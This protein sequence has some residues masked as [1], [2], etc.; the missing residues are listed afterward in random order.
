MKYKSV[1]K[2]SLFCKTL[3]PAF[4]NIYSH[5]CK[6][7]HENTLVSTLFFQIG[8]SNYHNLYITQHFLCILYYIGILFAH[9]FHYPHV[10]HGFIEYENMII[11]L[12]RV[13]YFSTQHCQCWISHHKI[14]WS[15]EA[16]RFGFRLLD[17]LRNLS[18]TSAAALPR[19]LSNLQAI[20]SI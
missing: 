6:S 1:F 16:M 4:R 11:Y 7:G 2:N 8:V 14:S 17:S 15:L 3:K 9:G 18:D 5:L 12:C 10:G 13:F 19:C 20:R